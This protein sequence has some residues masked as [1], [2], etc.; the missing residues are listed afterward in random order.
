MLEEHVACELRDVGG[1][2][3]ALNEMN[4]L[5]RP[6]IVLENAFESGLEIW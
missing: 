3:L 2:D 5:H 6:C 4:R 1:L